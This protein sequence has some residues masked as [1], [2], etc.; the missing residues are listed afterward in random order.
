M[1]IKIKK[2]NIELTSVSFQVTHL[3]S[4]TEVMTTEVPEDDEEL[5]SSRYESIDFTGA[6]NS[7]RRMSYRSAFDYQSLIVGPGD[8]TNQFYGTNT[9]QAV[10][11]IQSDT[12]IQQSVVYG[13]QECMKVYFI[14]SSGEVK[15]SKDSK[16]KLESLDELRLKFV[17]FQENSKHTLGINVFYSFT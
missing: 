9:S 15:L 13:D 4:F 16:I 14:S 2:K 7:S 3:E 8:D 11:I 1:D 17:V 5:Q 10:S 6:I 12:E